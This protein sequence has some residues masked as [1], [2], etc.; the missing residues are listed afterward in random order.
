L[1]EQEPTDLTAIWQNASFTLL[2]SSSLP[3]YSK[4]LNYGVI[5][6]ISLLRMLSLPWLAAG[7]QKTL[8]GCVWHLMFDFLL[9]PAP[10]GVR[11]LGRPG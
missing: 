7:R 9:R 8:A 10:E 11:S 1:R 4:C 5:E 3:R 6:R 2:Y